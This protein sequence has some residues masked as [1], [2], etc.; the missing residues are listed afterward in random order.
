[1]VYRLFLVPEYH[2]VPIVNT[3][4]ED[5]AE[6]QKLHTMLLGK[7]YDMTL[8]PA[9]HLVSPGMKHSVN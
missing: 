5:I 9:I 6:S 4:A 2:V 8:Q 7:E 3:R 1:M